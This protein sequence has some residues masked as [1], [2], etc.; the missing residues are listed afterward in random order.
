MIGLPRLQPIDLSIVYLDLYSSITQVT[1]P[2]HG[3]VAIELGEDEML[4]KTL[5]ASALVIVTLGAY[6]QAPAPAPDMKARREEM[7]KERVERREE[8]KKKREERRE[9]MEKKR[10][11]RKEKR[12]VRQKEREERQKEREDWQKKREERIEN[13]KP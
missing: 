10:E 1:L 7:K 12:E 3:I 5:I 11:E 8:M 6:A 13:K 9:E 2:E 4:R